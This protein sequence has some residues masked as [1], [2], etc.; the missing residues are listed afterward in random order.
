MVERVIGGLTAEQCLACVATAILVHGQKCIT[1]LDTLLTRYD[2]LLRKL[3][4]HS[5]TK[6]RELLDAIVNVWE[7]SQNAKIAVDRTICAKLCDIAFVA[8]WAGM[9]YL[10]NPIMYSTR[11]LRSRTCRRGRR[12]R[13][14]TH[15][16]HPPPRPRCRNA[17]LKLLAKLPNAS[18]PMV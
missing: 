15:S 10:E 3:I 11:R 7:G 13:V 4:D 12:A 2:I 1:H 14:R 5:S 16:T 18:S 6:A 8:E 9:K 17:K